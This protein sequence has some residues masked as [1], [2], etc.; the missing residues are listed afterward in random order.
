[1]YE[2]DFIHGCMSIL[3]SLAMIAIIVTALL[4]I[5][6][7]IKPADALTYCGVILG[8]VIVLILLVSVLVGLWS[9]M[10]VLQKIT[11]AALGVGMWWLL[12][13]RGEGRKKD[14]E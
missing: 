10:S 13:G 12:R 11:L 14:E 1:M 9:T 8:I 6:G 4:A 3:G 2:A 5:V 7:L